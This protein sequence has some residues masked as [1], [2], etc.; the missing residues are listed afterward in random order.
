M[1]NCLERL[2]SGSTGR[3]ILSA[4]SPRN[5][6][7]KPKVVEAAPIC[8]R[9]NCRL[10]PEGDQSRSPGS[11][12]FASAPWV[13]NG[14]FFLAPTPQELYRLDPTRTVRPIRDRTSPASDCGLGGSVRYIPFGEGIAIVVFAGD[15]GCA[16][17][18]RPWALICIPFGEKTGKYDSTG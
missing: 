11:R 12:G 5:C 7:S 10:F 4:F 15:P 3:S 17:A 1:E 2:T 14:D 9:M 18:R 13:R 16:A 6:I 8:R